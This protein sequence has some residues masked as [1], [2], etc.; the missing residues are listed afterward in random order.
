VRVA[1]VVLVALALSGC[2]TTAEKSAKLER[3]AKHV[4]VAQK[5]LTITQA[6]ADVKV[7]RAVFLHS[8][9]G[10]AA[11]VTLRNGS[12]RSLRLVPIAIAIKNARGSS[13]YS[14]SAPG[15]S[16]TL[17]SVALLPA[18]GELT[19]IDDQIQGAAATGTVTARVG[20]APSAV[21]TL[22]KMSVEGARLHED[23]T[24]GIG[25]EGTVVN[26]SAVG[27]QELVVYALA[28]RAGRIVAAGRAILPTLSAGASTLFQAFLIGDPRGATL[29]VSAPATTLG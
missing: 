17:V 5:G 28:R 8:S 21:G 29:Q 20:E 14:N 18:H 27:Q 23:P 15:L 6:S 2:E 3:A 26:H 22:P 11:V 4:T 12:A 25:V 16:R 9:E 7:V 10:G 1:A 24:N 19:W 13:V